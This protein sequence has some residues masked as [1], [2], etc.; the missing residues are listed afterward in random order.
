[1]EHKVTP[2]WIDQQRDKHCGV[3]NYKHDFYALSTDELRG[4][5][6]VIKAALDALEAAYAEIARLTAERDAAARDLKWLSNEYKFC[7]TCKR[8]NGR[9]VRDCNDERC[10]AENH[11][12]WRGLCAEN[13]PTG[14]RE[15]T[16]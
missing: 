14:A 11:Y 7:V 3:V 16:T 9:G 5:R 12:V 8:D 1:M 15:A 2:E 6:E 4:L 13:A 10:D